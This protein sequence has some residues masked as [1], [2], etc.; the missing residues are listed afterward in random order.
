MN[1][2]KKDLNKQKIIAII[3]A[4]GTSTGL[5]NKNIRPINNKPLIFWPINAAKK[6]KYINQVVVSTESVKIKKVAQRFGA[7]VP[8]MRP[9]NLAKSN[10]SSIDGVIH[11]LNHF[12]KNKIEFD[13][14]VLLEPT[15]P[16]TSHKDINK[17]LSI[18]HKNRRK[19]SSIV[20][21]SKNISHHP[22][23]LVKIRS[24]GKLKPYLKKFDSTMRQKISPLYFFDGSIY[25][26]KVET[27]FRKKTFYHDNTLP[28]VTHKYKSFE[29]DDIID[30]ICV[31]AIFKN[32]KKIK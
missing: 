3:L 30:H 13:Y 27:I 16:L 29:I 11:C 23:F 1:S 32:K 5:K 24:N 17:A 10:S 9:K 15:S 22:S 6:S 26:S 19:A 28:Y 7:S 31:E 21:V 4:K 18:L 20:G 8:F 25:I 12:K 2:L 14:V